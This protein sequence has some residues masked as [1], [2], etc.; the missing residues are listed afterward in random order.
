MRRPHH[1]DRGHDP[2]RDGSRFVRL[3]SELS[4]LTQLYDDR[5]KHQRLFDVIDMSMAFVYL[6]I[7]AVLKWVDKV[8]INAAAYFAAAYPLIFLSSGLLPMR[9]WPA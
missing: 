6:L 3:D 7:F 9:R 4:R 5:L 2:G 1:R 8:E